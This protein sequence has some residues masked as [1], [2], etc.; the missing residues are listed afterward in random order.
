VVEFAKTGSNTVSIVVEDGKDG[1][2]DGNATQ[3][4]DT[5]FHN[6]FSKVS[7][8]FV[9]NMAGFI[10]TGHPGIGELHG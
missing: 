4:H 10:L 8:Q 6:P 7:A 5:S 3:T 1:K 9:S 2:N